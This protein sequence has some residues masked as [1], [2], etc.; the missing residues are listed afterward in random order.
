MFKNEKM[1]LYFGLNVGIKGFVFM[2][3][4]KIK[5]VELCNGL[6]IVLCVDIFVFVVRDVY[7]LVSIYNWIGY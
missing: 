6:N 1:E 4:F 2:D 7:V 5:V 3:Y